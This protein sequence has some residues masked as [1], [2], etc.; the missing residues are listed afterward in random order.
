MIDWW[1]HNQNL[2][3]EIFKGWGLADHTKIIQKF[4]NKIYHKYLHP[5]VIRYVMYTLIQINRSQHAFVT[6]WP[7]KAPFTHSRIALRIIPDLN[8]WSSGVQHHDFVAVPVWVRCELGTYTEQY[9][10]Y[11]DRQGSNTDVAGKAPGVNPD[12]TDEHGS[13]WAFTRSF[14]GRARSLL[15]D[16]RSVEKRWPKPP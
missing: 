9:G 14:Y 12:C 15:G 3:S 6:K 13:N 1:C 2:V 7:F 5:K 11:T 8:P 4:L 10:V 16:P